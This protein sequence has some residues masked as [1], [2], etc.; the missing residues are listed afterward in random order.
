MSLPIR[1]LAHLSLEISEDAF[2]AEADP[3]FGF[4]PAQHHA[5]RLD[6][7]RGRGVEVAVDVSSAF[8]QARVVEACDHGGARPEIDADDV[9]HN[10]K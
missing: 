9:G 4:F 1:L 3:F 7:N 2:A 8:R 5:V 6:L 10:G